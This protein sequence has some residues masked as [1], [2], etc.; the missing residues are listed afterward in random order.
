MSNKTEAAKDFIWGAIK[1]IAKYAVVLT[2]A[3]LIFSLTGIG[4]LSTGALAGLA[5]GTAVVD[6][7]INMI[8]TAYNAATN[9]KTKKDADDRYNAMVRTKDAEIVR[10]QGE[11]TTRDTQITTLQGQ[12]SAL[13]ADKTALKGTIEGN[14]NTAGNTIVQ[15]NVLRMM[16]GSG[17]LN[18]A[19]ATSSLDEIERDARNIR[20]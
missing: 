7:G 1:T 2:G 11:V 4:D 20:S 15:V 3:S 8:T 5:I 14:K 9:R 13:E 12:V 10:L 17:S 18:V 16:V 6:T 19:A